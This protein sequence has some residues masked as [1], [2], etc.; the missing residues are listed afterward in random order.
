MMN[1]CRGGKRSKEDIM[2]EEVNEEVER[3]ERFACRPRQ[4]LLSRAFTIK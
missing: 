2:R 3:K 4:A 1:I